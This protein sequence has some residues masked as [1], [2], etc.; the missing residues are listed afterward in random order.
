MITI[1]KL[2]VYLIQFMKF[3]KTQFKFRKALRGFRK[4]SETISQKKTIENDS[5]LKE[6]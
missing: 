3:F 4:T 6:Y 2:L 1:P 5:F